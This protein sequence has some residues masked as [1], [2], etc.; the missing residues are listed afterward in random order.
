MI[1][2]VFWGTK[3]VLLVLRSVILFA[4]LSRG[5]SDSKPWNLDTKTKRNLIGEENEQ[6]EEEQ[7][8]R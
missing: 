3:R 2:D 5:V 8:E 1:N 4:W 6:K 7:N